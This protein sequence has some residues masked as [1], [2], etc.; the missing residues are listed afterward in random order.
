MTY[1]VEQG[2]GPSPKKGNGGGGGGGLQLWE[3]KTGLSP[4]QGRNPVCPPQKG[5]AARFRG[6]RLT[7]KNYRGHPA[8]KETLEDAV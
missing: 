7:P 5:V 4:V 8:A 3:G 6:K 2:R 1:E